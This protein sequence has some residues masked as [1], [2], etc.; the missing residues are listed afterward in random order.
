MHRKSK[1]RKRKNAY[2]S[3]SKSDYTENPTEHYWK[4]E[5]RMGECGV[6]KKLLRVRT[7]Y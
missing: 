2:F 7:H 4:S 6:E 5:G 3:S 1:A